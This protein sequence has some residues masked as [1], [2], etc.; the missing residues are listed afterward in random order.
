MTGRRGA[1]PVP[2][3]R[4]DHGPR[5][6]GRDRGPDAGGPLRGGP[7]GPVPPRV[8]GQLPARR[9]PAHPP[10]HR[11]ARRRPGQGAGGRRRHGG[12]EGDDAQDLRRV[13][14]AGRPQGDRG[15]APPRAGRHWAPERLPAQD[16]V[17]D[18]IDCLEHITSVFDFAVPA[19]RRTPARARLD[20]GPGQSP[21]PGAH[22]TA[23]EAQG[24]GRPDAD[25]VQEHAPAVGP[26]EV[27]KHPDNA[28]V[29]ERLR[30]YWDG[31]LPGQGLAPGTRRS[32]ARRSSRSTRS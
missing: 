17:E 11:P 20:P 15:G 22:R 14:P 28:R 9:R 21:G 1:A 12:V 8:H 23:G 16:A 10:G 5:H 6:R 32:A 3:R 26:G 29:P 30:N 25:G 27:R 24:P 18:G 31:Y 2:G 7:P 19:G 13:G 4:C